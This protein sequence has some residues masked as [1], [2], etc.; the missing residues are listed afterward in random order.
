MISTDMKSGGFV[1]HRTVLIFIVYVKIKLVGFILALQRGNGDGIS[2]LGEIGRRLYNLVYFHVSCFY[3]FFGLGATGTIFYDRETIGVQ[4][5]RAIFRNGMCG[6]HKGLKAARYGCVLFDIVDGLH[7]LFIEMKTRWK[8][9][10][11]NDI[12]T[13]GDQVACRFF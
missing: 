5:Q 13:A 10:V 12:A 7:H 3:P 4:S 1:N 8:E 9:R 11:E 6:D 2:F